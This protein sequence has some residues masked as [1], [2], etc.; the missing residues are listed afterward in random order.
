MPPFRTH[1]DPGSLRDNAIAVNKLARGKQSSL[2]A[3]GFNGEAHKPESI[4]DEN[5]AKIDQIRRAY[6]HMGLPVRVK[7][8]ANTPKI[9]ISN[10]PVFAQYEKAVEMEVDESSR[11]EIA[12]PNTKAPVGAVPKGATVNGPVFSH[13]HGIEYATN[14]QQQQ[15]RARSAESTLPPNPASIYQQAIQALEGSDVKVKTEPMEHVPLYNIPTA[16][17]SFNGSAT[18][19]NKVEHMDVT[20]T[21]QYESSKGLSAS[22]F[23]LA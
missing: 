13:W 8:G 14:V 10:P 9:S 1:T 12:L 2:P 7:E 11:N 22:S 4:S 5:L 3:S 23:G 17:P 20:M 19:L 16:K 18:R 15:P 21:P 6:P